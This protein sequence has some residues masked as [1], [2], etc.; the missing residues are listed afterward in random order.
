MKQEDLVK[1]EDVAR[2]IGCGGCPN[3]TTIQSPYIC[4]TCGRMLCGWCGEYCADH[5]PEEKKPDVQR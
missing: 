5:K 4:K 1:W 2:A 3:I